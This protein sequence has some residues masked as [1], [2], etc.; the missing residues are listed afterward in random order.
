MLE[1]LED[2]YLSAK[3]K[4]KLK[5]T[6]EILE[7]KHKYKEEKKQVTEDFEKKMKNIEQNLGKYMID[8][9]NQKDKDLK[10]FVYSINLKK[11]NERTNINMKKVKENKLVSCDAI[12]LE[13]LSSKMGNIGCEQK[14]NHE[15]IKNWNQ[16]N[17]IENRSLSEKSKE[18]K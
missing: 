11:R 3:N 15:E 5:H 16:N 12:K 4:L 6:K 2:E 1:Q 14:N 13:Y 17:E 9:I 7:L 10:L 8:N 18:K